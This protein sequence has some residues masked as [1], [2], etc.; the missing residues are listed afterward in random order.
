[1]LKFTIKNYRCFHESKPLIFEIGSGFTAFIGPNNS[2]KSSILK[3]FYEFQPFFDQLIKDRHY[4]T[5]CLAG[6][7]NL[8]LQGIND[9]D[10]IFSNQD[11]SNMMIDICIPNTSDEAEVE[12]LSFEINRLTKITRLSTY[13]KNKKFEF[14]TNNIA[15]GPNQ[16]VRT[17]GNEMVS[18][19]KIFESME[20]MQNILYIG[21]YRNLVNH[22][23]NDNYFGIQIGESLITQWHHW[24]SGNIAQAKLIIK[25]CNDL[26]RLFGFKDFN[27][28][29]SADKKSMHAVIDGEPYKVD[30]LG[31]GI[32]QFII[33]LINVA[34]KQP[35]LIL[36]DEPE[37]HL[38]PSLQ[39]EFLML[40]AS[41]S[42]STILFAT[43]SIGLAR[44][45]TDG[46]IYSIKKDLDNKSLVNEYEKTIDL[47]QFLGEMSFSTFRE[48]GYRTLLLV[49]GVNDMKTIQQFLRKLNKDH[50]VVL[51]PLGGSELIH[52]DRELEIEELKR[53]VGSDVEIKALIDSEKI[54][55]QA[56]YP[57]NVQKFKETCTKVNIPLHILKYRAIENYLTETAIQKAK[58][59]NSYKALGPHQARN[60]LPYMWAKN[61][62][63]RIAQEMT[64]DDFI[65]TDL[66]KFLE[67]L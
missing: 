44:A 51:L 59:S 25:I 60:E 45:M 57:D 54:S 6:N 48:I 17:L 14:D 42:T 15:F 12:K 49:E 31:A 13:H 2:G 35:K 47:T 28:S 41:Y 50:Q 66:G 23:S 40:L 3:F 24:Q 34:I 9:F 55:E 20:S 52:S 18:F 62:N 1:M 36:I 39:M 33:C 30:S 10:E 58:C 63:W 65:N 46:K 8:L 11:S 43:H 22:G 21:P 5:S 38:H 37:S 56:M 64:K 7:L 61:E 26:K 27:L 67:S 32:S 53:V 29:A 4:L 19:Y 16:Q